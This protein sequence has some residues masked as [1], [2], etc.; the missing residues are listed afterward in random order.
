MDAPSHEMRVT[1]C[2]ETLCSGPVLDS[3]RHI[4]PGRKQCMIVD[5]RFGLL[6]RCK[7]I[8]NTQITKLSA[9]APGPL[10]DILR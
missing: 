2:Y 10:T 9:S 4:S 3:K 1:P 6:E 8:T 7:T 5:V